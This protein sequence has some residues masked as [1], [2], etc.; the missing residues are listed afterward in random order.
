SNDFQGH[1]I[2]TGDATPG[3]FTTR[4]Y[5]IGLAANKPFAKAHS[6]NGL[7]LLSPDNL[8]SRGPQILAATFTNAGAALH[9]GCNLSTIATPPMPADVA[10]A[11]IGGTHDGAESFAG[12]MAEV[13]VYDRLLSADE[14]AE[15]WGYLAAKYAIPVAAPVDADMDGTFDTC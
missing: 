14:E 8:K 9:S 3:Q 11:Y 1:I 12:D 4:G 10:P 6:T 13:L 7:W 2:G 5:G 15:V